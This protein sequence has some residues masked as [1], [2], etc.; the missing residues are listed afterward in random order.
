MMAN[1]YVENIKILSLEQEGFRSNRS[2][3]RA[4]TQLGFCMEDAHIRNKDIVLWYLDFKGA[5]PSVDHDHMVTTLSFLRLP[6]DFINII[7]NL[8]TG[9]T[10]E[11][12]TPNGHT[13]PW[14]SGVAPYKE[15]PSHRCCST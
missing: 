1:D 13:P 14:G 15:T 9:A 10:V 7:T 2:C 8:Y 5:F 6:E 4:T 3:A 11:F 12:V